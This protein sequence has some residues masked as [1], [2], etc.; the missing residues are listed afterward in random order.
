MRYTSTWLTLAVLILCLGNSLQAQDPDPAG[1]SVD[2]GDGI[3]DVTVVLDAIDS[4]H[5]A[6]YRLHPRQE[7]VAEAEALR[8]RLPALDYAHAAGFARLIALLE[9]GHSRLAHVQLA[10]HTHPELLEVEFLQVTP[11]PGP[12]E[13]CLDLAR[14]PS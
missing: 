7:F 3:G 5:P 1:Q 9:D 14:R 4:I 12:V 2:P 10:S 13:A 6:P 11:E 8:R